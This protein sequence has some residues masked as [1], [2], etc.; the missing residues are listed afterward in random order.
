[1]RKIINICGQSVFEPHDPTNGILKICAQK[2]FT[3]IRTNMLLKV[4]NEVHIIE[5][6]HS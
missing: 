3:E 1:M 4:R 2:A 6:I 5:K